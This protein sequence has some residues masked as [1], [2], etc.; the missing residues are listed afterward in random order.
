MRTILALINNCQDK[1]WGTPPLSKAI[2]LERKTSKLTDETFSILL[3]FINIAAFSPRQYSGRF[4]AN[5]FGS[6]FSLMCELIHAKNAFTQPRNKRPNL[7]NLCRASH[8][9]PDHCGSA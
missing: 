3:F 6:A 7:R 5:G 1:N 4:L 9:S 8:C 2:Y